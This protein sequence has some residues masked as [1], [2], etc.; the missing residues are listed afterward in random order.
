MKIGVLGC[1]NMGG[2]IVRGIAK[3]HPTIE[4]LLSD[5]SH[6]ALDALS[7]VGTPCAAQEWF[8]SPEKTPDVVLLAVKPQYLREACA[9][10]ASVQS[11]VLWVSI[12]A[13]I[14]IAS[15]EE[16]LPT[17]SK[18]CR[19]MPNTPSLIGKGMSGCTMNARC[20]E[21]DRT[22][23]EVILESMGKYLFVP[24]SMLNAV[25]GLSGSGPAYV[26]MV[27]EALADGGVAAGLS[28]SDA[29]SCA[30]QTVRGAAAMVD[31]TGEVPA[32]LRS[33]VMS[34]G[35][36]TAAAVKSLEEDGL[37]AALIRA[38]NAS[39]QQAARLG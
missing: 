22:N 34:A 27:I 31:E 6:K 25:T 15:L 38:V 11:S 4:I 20:T 24:E 35:G 18:I 5:P 9:V 39:A 17:S 3:K 1:G 36:A 30:I 10:F 23:A 37:R 7:H 2:A 14:T 33:H 21:K 8:S 13:G 16:V 26:Y 28:Y 19:V 29:L 12:A 32:V